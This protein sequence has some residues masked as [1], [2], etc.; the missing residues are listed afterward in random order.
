MS[1]KRT[2]TTPPSYRRHKG[3]GNAFVELGGKRIY[4]GRYDT[5]ESRERYY[6]ELAQWEANGHKLIPPRDEITIVEIVSL[7]LAHAEIHY[8]KPTGMPGVEFG[9]IIRGCRLLK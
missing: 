9:N 4:L 1:K 6:R 3:S 5:P 2:R 8:Q 7:Y